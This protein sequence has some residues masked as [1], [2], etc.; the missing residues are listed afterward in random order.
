MRFFDVG[1]VGCFLDT[2]THGTEARH[3]T[4][5]KIVTL[6]LRVQPFDATLA[7]AM[8]NGV[9]ATLFTLNHSE[10]KDH[11]RRVEFA[12]G[13]P[14]Q[15]LHVF[16]APDTAQA[17]MRFEQAKI[18]ST[19]ARTQK[20]IRGY[21]LVFR[22]SFGPC[23]RQDLEY[24]QDWHLGQRFVTFEEA[25]PGMFDDTAEATEDDEPEA[26]AL[27][28]PMFDDPRD[29]PAQAPAKRGRGRPK[30]PAGAV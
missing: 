12:L 21:A 8:S 22:V 23:G 29:Q 19:Y 10:P 11:L 14:R 1:K 2:I 7:N 25:E 13:V 20:D 6:V 27:P 24:I 30:A 17:S 15:N 3:D 5:V 16:A 18:V 4:E 28:A 9:R 26:A